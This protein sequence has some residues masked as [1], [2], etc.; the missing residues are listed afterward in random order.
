MKLNKNWW[1]HLAPKSMIGRRREVEQ[2][3]DDFVRSVDYG[4]EWA[5]TAANPQGVFRL[6]PG[7]AIPVVHMVFMGDRPGFI[8]ESRKLMDGH[9]TVS[10]KTEYGLGALGEGELAIQPTISVEVVTDPA[11]LAAAMRGAR[12]IDESTIR[13]PSLVFS[14]PAHFL[15]SP[16]YY[17]ESAFVLYQHIFGAGASYPED[18]FFYVGVSTRSWQKRWSEHRRAIETGSPLLFHRRFRE[19]KRRGCLTYVHHKVMAITD[20]LEQLYEA[21]EFLV[22]GHWDDERRLNMVPGGKSGLFY[23]RENGLLSK[24]VVPQPDDRDKILYKWLNDH[25]RLGLPAP[26][27]TEKWK[28]NDWATAQICGREGRL[29]VDQVKAIRELAKSH[30]PEEIYVRIG[31]KGVDQVKRVLDGKTYT[32]IA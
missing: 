24:G 28:D 3:L 23:L 21:E 32:R 25:P 4:R 19:E 14:V 1:E 20:D 30:T 5:R 22:A 15:I 29:S 10:R 11:L 16:K 26:W 8:S 7:Q 2:L 6:K 17:P 9:R 12:Q 31:A 27:V 13:S 18:G